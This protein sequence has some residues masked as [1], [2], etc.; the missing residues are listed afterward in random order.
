MRISLSSWLFA[1]ALSLA[2]TAASTRAD[3]ESVLVRGGAREE[4]GIL[5]EET[6]VSEPNLTP[7]FAQNEVGNGVMPTQFDEST[8]YL[9][10]SVGSDFYT[11]TERGAGFIG[12]GE[13]VFMRPYGNFGQPELGFKPAYRAWIGYQNE[14]G[15]GGRIRYWGYD[16]SR[17][18]PGIAAYSYEFHTLD[19]ELTQQVDYY[20]WNFLVSG[21]VRQAESR[22][23]YD[24]LD[25]AFYRET[26][27]FSGTGLTFSAQATRDL[28]GSGSFRFLA[29][30]RWSTLFG[31]SRLGVIGSAPN[32][33]VPLK[34]TTVNILEI[35]IGPQFVRELNSGALLTIFGGVETQHWNNGFGVPYEDIGLVGLGTSVSILR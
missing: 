27:G 17:T 2:G 34:N 15:L 18:F 10:T 29:G 33:D 6:T 32:V 24:S 1:A 9:P 21:G 26:S 25:Q 12:G 30:A 8:D 22:S 23:V 13:V 3:E 14:E 11:A 31:N 28:N 4:S 19:A 5:A 7:T 16:Q 20:S 35:S